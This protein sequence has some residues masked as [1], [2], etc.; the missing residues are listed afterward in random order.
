MNSQL[1]NLALRK[2]EI[3]KV[4]STVYKVNK[5]IV[6]D[7]LIVRNQFVMTLFTV[8]WGVNISIDACLSH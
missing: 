5:I 6:S 3:Q 2:Y 4:H 8:T 7:I 1:Q